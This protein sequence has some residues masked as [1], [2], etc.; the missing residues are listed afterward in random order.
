MLLGIPDDNPDGLPM[1]EITRSA[2]PGVG[3]SVGGLGVSVNVGGMFIV[4]VGVLVAVLMIGT[5][6]HTPWN[7]PNYSVGPFTVR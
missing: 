3:V 5:L 2:L 6:T 7:R 4:A 1:L